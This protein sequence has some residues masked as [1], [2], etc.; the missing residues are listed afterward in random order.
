MTVASPAFWALIVGGIFAVVAFWAQLVMTSRPSTFG[1]L[2]LYAIFFGG[3]GAG[4]GYLGFYVVVFV[5]W[6]SSV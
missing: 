2:A 4:V 6:G 3:L 1:N 5:K